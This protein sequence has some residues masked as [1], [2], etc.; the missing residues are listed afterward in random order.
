MNS[1]IDVIAENVAAL[2]V[3]L[4]LEHIFGRF[5][6]I[7]L[8]KIKANETVNNEAFLTFENDQRNSDIAFTWVISYIIG[9]IMI[10]VLSICKSK[11]IYCP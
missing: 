2:F 1:N 6:M 7:Y 4:D 11:L 8:Q 3:I 9:G 10:Y 5:F